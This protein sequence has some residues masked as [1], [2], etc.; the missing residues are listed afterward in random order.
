MIVYN[1]LSAQVVEKQSVA[2]MQHELQM[3]LKCRVR[4]GNDCW[5]HTFSPRVPLHD[6][7]LRH[8]S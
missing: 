7:P 5:L 3:L 6:H 8:C 2:A 4:N 1:L